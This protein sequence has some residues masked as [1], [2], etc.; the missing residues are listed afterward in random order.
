MTTFV[1]MCFHLDMEK[2]NGVKGDNRLS[3][4]AYYLNSLK[5]ISSHPNIVNLVLWCDEDAAQVVRESNP[6]AVIKVFPG[7][8][9]LPRYVEQRELYIKCLKEMKSVMNGKSRLFKTQNLESIADYLL[10]V[11]SKMDVINWAIEN[12]QFGTSQFFWIDAGIFNSRYD[13]VRGDWNLRISEVKYF[14]S[15]FA[16][17][18]SNQN[19][20]NE[21][22]E[23]LFDDIVYIPFDKNIP[24]IIAG[25][26]LIKEKGF[27]EFYSFYNKFID[28]LMQEKN[29][30]TSEQSIFTLMYLYDKSYF[31]VI[32]SPKGY[33]NFFSL[34]Q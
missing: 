10:L 9:N 16:V 2:L 28:I 6:R 29:M 11:N 25:G 3:Y 19:I 4:E 7:L 23:D 22:K 12:N 15:T 14:K 31:D 24:Q 27:E 32:Y 18:G 20:I 34:F 13:T 33:T 8:S 17:S 21:L 1:T 5:Q 30:I 26:F